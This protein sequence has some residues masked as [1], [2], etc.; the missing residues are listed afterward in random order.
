VKARDQ[1][2]LAP[3]PA[4]SGYQLPALQRLHRSRPLRQDL[5]RLRRRLP[6]YFVT[7]VPD[8]K[9]DETFM[10][11]DHRRC[12]ILDIVQDVGELEPYAGAFVV[13]PA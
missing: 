11:G 6:S 7:A 4:L 10:A 9:I 5:Q 3:W 2:G 8:W 13:E 12:R 1:E